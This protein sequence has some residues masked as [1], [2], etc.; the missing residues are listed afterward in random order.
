MLSS[1]AGWL[2][3]PRASWHQQLLSCIVSLL[4]VLNSLFDVSCIAAALIRSQMR[5][6]ILLCKAARHLAGA[7]HHAAI[8]RLLFL[9]LLHSLVLLDCRSHGDMELALAAHPTLQQ[10]VFGSAN[11]AVHLA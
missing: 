5:T 2:P 3:L 8:S 6:P 11:L 9:T 1:C 10:P 4:L 7:L